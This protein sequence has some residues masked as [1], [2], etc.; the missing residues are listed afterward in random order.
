MLTNLSAEQL[1]GRNGQGYAIGMGAMGWEAICPIALTLMAFF[2]L[3]QY[4]KSGITTVPEFFEERYDRN[5]RVW[6]LQFS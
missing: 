2:F 6:C 5:T 1:V 3:P 4:L